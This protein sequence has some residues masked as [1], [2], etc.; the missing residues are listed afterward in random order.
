MKITDIKWDTD[1]E[2]VDGL[3]EE[4][5]IPDGIDESEVADFLSDEYGFC[6]ESFSFVNP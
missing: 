3:P 1:G 4:A 5:D 6:V 2:F